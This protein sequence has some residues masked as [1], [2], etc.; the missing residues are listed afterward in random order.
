MPNDRVVLELPPLPEFVGTGRLVV[1]AVA[2]AGGFS[3]GRI[4]DL[5]VAV[6]EAVTNALR[7]H[8]AAGI[9]ERV[10]LVVSRV[11]EG[12]IIDVM[13]SGV[14]FDPEELDRL[15]YT[16][17]AGTLER[18]LGLSV[19][20]SLFADTTIERRPGRGMHVRLVAKRED[21]AQGDL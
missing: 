20:R 8:E 5:K 2:R 9:V 21:P 13:D 3:E 14:G 17:P 19:I 18:G 10:S 12:L 15:G 16:P 4:E 6:S 1:S 11:P 7:A